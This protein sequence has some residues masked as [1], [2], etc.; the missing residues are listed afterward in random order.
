[1]GSQHPV[2]PWCECDADPATDRHR[3]N[4]TIVVVG[5]LADQIDATRCHRNFQG[6][7]A[8]ELG[9]ENRLQPFDPS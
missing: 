9:P 8:I 2:V 5:V 7:R 4:P 3:K 1:M 6:V